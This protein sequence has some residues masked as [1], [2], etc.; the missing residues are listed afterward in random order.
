MQTS[1]YKLLFCLFAIG[2]LPGCSKFLNK[3]PFASLTPDQAFKNVNDL[4][5]YTNSFYSFVPAASGIYGGDNTSDYIAGNNIPGLLT[6]QNNPDQ[7]GSWSWTTLRNI[8]YFLQNDNEPSIPIAT[9]NNYAG[10]ARFFR[11]WF[12]FIRAW[13]LFPRAR[14]LSECLNFKFTLIFFVVNYLIRE[15]L[16]II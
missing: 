14:D 11:A 13:D 8:N 2:A 4:A 5:L 6:P 7:T 1:F 10:L 3:P 15:S 12:Y 9:R 16:Y